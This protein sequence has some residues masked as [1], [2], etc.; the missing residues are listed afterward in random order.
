MCIRDRYLGA[1]CRRQQWTVIAS[2]YCTH[3]GI[4]SQ[5]RSLCI[6]RDRPRSYFQVPVTRRAAALWTC[7]NLSVTF[8]G[9]EDKTDIQ[10]AMCFSTSL[11]TD[12]FNS[13]LWSIRSK[14]LAKWTNKILV[15]L[16]YV[17][18]L[19]QCVVCSLSVLSA[20]RQSLRQSSRTNAQRQTPNT[21]RDVCM[22]WYLTSAHCTL[23][24]L[25][26]S[27]KCW[28][29]TSHSVHYRS[30]WGWFLRARWPNQQCRSTEG[31]QLVVEVR[32]ESQHVTII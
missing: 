22:C 10:T 14:A 24:F 30:F 11:L 23:C 7:C 21:V 18:R 17:F 13:M 3:W 31:N 19:L 20:T 12:L 29:L 15:C 16:M 4:S 1:R 28:G 27:S 32:F 26:S 25:I 2:L 5:C 6:S 8:F 9:V